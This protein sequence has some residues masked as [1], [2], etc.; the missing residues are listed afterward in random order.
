M[1]SATSP[2]AASAAIAS[3]RFVHSADLSP[4]GGQVVW[5][6]SRLE[7]DEE[8][9]DLLLTQVDPTGSEVLVST[10]RS[11]DPEFSPDGR[12]VA[13][14]HGD[15]ETAHVAVIDLETRN[16]AM[17]TSMPQGVAGRPR[18]SPDGRKIAFTVG[19]ES[20]DRSVP[21]R[22]TRALGWLDGV[23]LVEDAIN[24]IHVLDV[25]THEI[26]R[27]THD[28]SLLGTPEWHPD[29]ASLSYI[30]ES[31]ADDWQH[32][33]RVRTVDLSGSGR[34]IARLDE[35]FSIAVAGEGAGGRGRIVATTAGPS[36]LGD[37]LRG[38]LFTIGDDGAVTI[39][40]GDLDINGDVIAD[41]PIPFTD[42]KS[43]ILVHRGDALVR[44]QV[45]DRLEIHRIALGGGTSTS[46]EVGGPGSVYPI[47]VRG[48]RLL[49]ARG[50]LLKAPD[51]W[52]R[53]MVSG[54]DT[55]ITYTADDNAARLTSLRVERLTARS[56]GG[57]E[58]QAV[59]VS[60][61]DAASPL[62]TVLLIHGGPESAFGEALF[63][64]AQLLCE[65]G[66]GVL[67]ANPRGSRGYGDEFLAS[68]RG[69]WGG[70]DAADLLAA[71]DEAVDRGLA[72]PD[73]LG[74]SGLSYGGYMT[75]WL[76]GQTDRFRAAVAENPVTNLVS[77]YGTSDIGLTFAPQLT[78]GPISTAFDQYVAS[79]PV[80]NAE[81]VTTPTLLIVSDEDH[82][83]PPEQ[84]FQFYSRLRSTGCTAELLI[85]PG[86]SHAGA[87]NESPVVRRAQNDALVE[88]MTRH[89]LAETRR[90]RGEDAAEARR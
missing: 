73:R 14:L 70:I 34:E 64:D 58:V 9:I 80:T 1:I 87:V 41:L 26:T 15:A 63:L 74:V 25:A 60:P 3:L 75:T 38:R 79:S 8:V 67:M 11:T 78:G 57:P 10:G 33:G 86:A 35:V 81:Q 23:G 51:F 90:L 49:Y 17:L 5:C 40:S 76:I 66:F 6:R 12:S 72:D 52:V 59:F 36:L 44:V 39:R 22:V 69:D 45:G 48:D 19:P 56:P 43:L 7:G 53:D 54:A 28:D 37:D 18:W 55:R 21:Y 68:I 61:I 82:R 85:L 89:L 62:P 71:V 32:H 20:V 50:D 42:Q 2:G 84:S 24:D 46:L 88:W 30:A 31:G 27:L 65:A 29:S 77:I 83:C 47:A 16:L 13:F 4:D